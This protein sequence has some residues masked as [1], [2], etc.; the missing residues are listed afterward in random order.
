M[1]G[2]Y[3]GF[4]EIFTSLFYRMLHMA[5]INDPH[6]FA[7]DDDPSYII[8]QYKKLEARPGI[9]ECFRILPDAGFT[10]WALTAEDIECV[11]GYFT[12]NGIEMPKEHFVSCDSSGI[13]KPDPKVYQMMLEKLGNDEKWFAAAHNWDVAATKLTG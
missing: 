9:V 3:V 4:R 5:G 8:E 7:T 13:G 2:R 6:S 1:N 10:I 11:G 12:H